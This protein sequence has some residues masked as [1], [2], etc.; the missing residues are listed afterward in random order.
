MRV[1]Q[2]L[3]FILLFLS[4]GATL[5]AQVEGKII[6]LPDNKTY[7]VSV[8]PVT[9]LSAAFSITNSAQITLVAPT[10]GFELTRLRGITGDWM[11]SGFAKSPSENHSA[12]YYSVQLN[13][14]LTDVVYT[15]NEEIILFTFENSAICVGDVSI[16]DDNND[17]FLPPNSQ[18]LNVGNLFTIRG[19][20]PV[21]AYQG[22]AVGSASCPEPLAATASATVG[23]LNCSDDVTT[24][25][26]DIQGGEAPFTIIY[27]NNE[28]GVVDSVVSNQINTPVT[29]QN[30][31]GGDYTIEINDAK[32]SSN[33]LTEVVTAPDPIEFDFNIQFAN[34]EESQDGVIEINTINRP[35]ATYEW[36]NGLTSTTQ[37]RDLAP[38][39]YSVTVTDD[40]GCSATKEAIVK[41]D[42]WIQMQADPVDI[43]CFGAA[44]GAIEMTTS[45][46]NPPFTYDW[47]NGTATGTGDNLNN[48]AAGTYTL[49]VT[50]NTGVCNQVQTLQVN[51]PAE[52]TAFALIDSSSLCEL[53]TE[54]VVT[55]DGVQNNRGAVGYSLDGIDFS[56]SNRF[57]LEAGASYT[58]TV[59]DEAGCGTDLDVTMPE[60]SGLAVELPEDLILKLGD[61]LQLEADFAATTEVSFNWGPA[62]GL[63]CTDCPNPDITPTSTTTYTLTVNDANGCEK[64]ASVIVYLSTTRRVYAPNTFSPNGDGLNDLYTIFTSTDAQSVNTLK[65]Y[66]R[67]GEKVYESPTDFEP[68]QEFR[69]GWDGRFR[70]EEAPNGVYVFMTEITFIDGRTEVFSGDLTLVR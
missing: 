64:Q 2:Y 49:T 12:D 48:L 65:I 46:K 60:P 4:F 21:N 24:M 54:S 57:V 70:G 18:F 17:P 22:S 23:S 59:Q 9:S 43:S 55:I 25:V 26:V 11:I 61:D 41:M 66:D 45:G 37:I 16:I 30:I 8:I 51:E 14:P 10:G 67:W 40:N 38:A 6:L 20:G 44:D 35:S 32:N 3:L 47:D 27:T 56:N 50:D 39:T 34:C 19:I 42:G 36:S 58:I 1:Q 5:S 62:E 13:S 15:A 7:Q 52:V 68:S 29:L 28:T 53:E 63:S 31:S 33:V 69:H